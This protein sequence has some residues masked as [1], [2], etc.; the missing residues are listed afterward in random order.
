[1]KLGEPVIVAVGS[2]EFSGEDKWGFFQ[3]PDIW[4]G[5]DGDL[6]LVVNI[7]A[8]SR[9][10]RHDPSE[11]FTSSDA[12]RTWHGIESGAA[13]R[14]SPIL[15]LPSG[16]QVSFGDS[17]YIYH[18]Q[19]LVKEEASPQR[20][21]SGL[22]LGLEPVIE[23]CLSSYGVA[24]NCFYRY[25]DVPQDKRQFPVRQRVSP[26]ASWEHSTGTIE[27]DDLLMRALV[28]DGWDDEEGNFKWE[29]FGHEF[30]VPT[31]YWQNRLSVLPDGTILWAHACQ[32]PG[33]RDR[34]D[35]QV[36]CLE[37]VDGGCTWR[38]RS[39]ITENH[40]PASAGYGAGE[41]SLALMPNGDLLC[42]M[43]T[44]MSNQMEDTHHLA[45]ARSTDGGRSWSVVPP[46]SEFSVT[47]ALVALENGMVALLYG[48]P[49][50]H[51]RVSANSGMSW[52][53]SMPLV[54]PSEADLTAM[55]LADWWKVRHDF[56]CANLDVVVTGPDRFLA[57]YSNF[58][59]ENA[60]HEICKSIEVREITC[61]A[62]VAA[63]K[64]CT[65]SITSR[66]ARTR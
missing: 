9:T 48:R 20:T 63:K 11:F 57:A 28:R 65:N 56:S 62:R 33:T 30:L 44:K 8:D 13:D 26:D 37:S 24:Y 64:R 14:S 31:P 16:G 7:G 55:P 29:E 53:E 5:G 12:G 41:Q 47:P 38:Y 22:E 49:G 17:R 51:V 27:M 60:D 36:V 46:I 32:D 34:Q 54:G 40:P 25:G 52:S 66:K 21:L 39:A 23:P 42:V 50:V 18:Y 61:P 43:R 59:Y 6:Y 35:W 19:A 10:G 58:Q 2:P 15:D 1:M 4:R 3:F 45:A